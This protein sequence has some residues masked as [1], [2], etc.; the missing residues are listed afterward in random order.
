MVAGQTIPPR[1]S[2]PHRKESLLHPDNNSLQRTYLQLDGSLILQSNV[3]SI[4]AEKS[5]HLKLRTVLPNVN[6]II[7]MS[8]A[9]ETINESP[10]LIFRFVVDGRFFCGMNSRETP[11]FY[12]ETVNFRCITA[13]D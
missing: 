3:I 8:K 7:F 12:D 6:N 9:A 4:E 1:N 10:V 13:P 2:F 11:A 5:Q